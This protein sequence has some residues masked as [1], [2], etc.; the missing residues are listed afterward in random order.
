MTNGRSRLF[1]I[2]LVSSLALNLLLV[3]VIIGRFAFGPP[4]P[5]YLDHLGWMLRTLDQKTRRELRPQL[6]AHARKVRPLRREIRAAQQQFENVL[7]QPRLN[8]QQLDA[9]LVRLRA[10]S[11]A[12]Q[13]SMHQEMTV[14]LKQ[15]SYTER[16]R[17]VHFLRHRQDRHHRFHRRRGD[18]GRPGAPPPRPPD[19]GRAN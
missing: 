1:N 16:K 14:I 2:V 3:G 15:M 10:A 17:F 4:R 19:N 11:D 8:E 9:A 5:P 7:L 12:Y 6:E 18:N 13:H